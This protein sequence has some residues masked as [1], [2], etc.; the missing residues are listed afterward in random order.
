[1]MFFSSD[2][3]FCDDKTFI[4]DNLP[5]RD[6]KQYDKY[7]LRMWN[8][9]TTKNDTIYVIGDFMDCDGPQSRSWEK[10]ILYVKKLKANVVLI[11]GNNED[12]VIKYFFDGN[13]QKFRD[14]CISIGFKDVVSSCE[15]TFNNHKFYLVHKPKDCKKGYINLFGHVH[16]SCGVYKPFGFNVG[17]CLNYFR[18]YSEQDIMHLI[19]MKNNYWD[20][21]PNVNK[22]EL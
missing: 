6:V 14:Y 17:C 16:R 20:K 5:F 22:H 1:M 8:K 15:V 12:R 7:V 18:L 9:Q 10:A 3:H 11:T 13:Y 19:N 4:N 21:D 2:T